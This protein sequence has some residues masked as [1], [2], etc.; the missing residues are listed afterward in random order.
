MRKSIT[1]ELIVEKIAKKHNI[2]KKLAR[3]VYSNTLIYN[4]VQEQILD[5]ADFL[6][7]HKKELY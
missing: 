4:V 6:I 3:K 7:Y 5:Q 1:E 2:T